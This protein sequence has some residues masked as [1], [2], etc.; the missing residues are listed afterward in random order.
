MRNPYKYNYYNYK[1]GSSIDTKDLLRGMC[2]YLDVHS[3]HNELETIV[4]QIL[5]NKEVYLIQ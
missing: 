5:E 2:T 1:D 3:I 4:A